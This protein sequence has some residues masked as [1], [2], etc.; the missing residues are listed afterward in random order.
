MNPFHYGNPV[1]PHHFL[2][3]KK[4]LRRTAQRIRS[5]QCSAVVGEP[6]TGKTSLLLY[7]AARET[8][9]HL[10]GNEVAPQRIFSFLDA[11]CFD[12]Q[13]N[14]TRFWVLALKPLSASIQ[15]SP[16]LA[17]A[18]QAC[19]D[20]G[21]NHHSL[22]QLFEQAA[23]Q[24][25]HLVLLIDEFEALLHLPLMCRS[26]FFGTL[27][28]LASRKPA[29]SLVIATRHA[30][31]YLNNL[32][33]QL[34]NTGSPYFNIFE[35]CTLS[36]FSEQEAKLLLH[37]A[38]GRFSAE[39]IDF[40]VHAA[41]T[42]PYLLQAMAAE[43]WDIYEDGDEDNP[44]ERRDRAGQALYDVAARILE[45]TWSV[46]SPQMRMAITVV[47]LAKSPHLLKERAFNNE[48]LLH[49]LRDFGPELRTL[50]K[51][52]YIKNHEIPQ[53]TCPWHI[54]PAVFQWWLIDELVRTVRSDSDFTRWIQ[55]QELDGLLTKQEKQQLIHAGKLL[56][57]WSKN[58]IS[59]LIKSIAG[60]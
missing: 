22:E 12:E 24:N 60:P 1:T 30:I 28:S 21:F 14:Q 50:E 10:Y 56:S 51:M 59:G 2:G 53:S 7:L 57:E 27:R 16:N 18:Y 44:V 39:D 4:E 38:D 35:E 52:G 49:D 33:Q 23:N 43:L 41:G 45:N 32:T 5:S 37:R 36:P 3:R 11:L 8:Q 48:A 9:V 20:N 42:H 58:G 34:N 26:E 47:V 13:M 15:T 55:A 25:F 40:I 29:L 17:A 46:W 6:R 31:N 19:V 54:L